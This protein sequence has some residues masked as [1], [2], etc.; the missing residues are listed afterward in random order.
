MCPGADASLMGSLMPAVPIPQVD[1]WKQDLARRF[2]L[3][4]GDLMDEV[5]AEKGK[6]FETLPY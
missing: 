4:F 2:K 3:T 6:G 1:S 5:G